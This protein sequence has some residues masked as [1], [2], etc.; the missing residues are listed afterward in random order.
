LDEADTYLRSVAALPAFEGLKI[1]MTVRTGEAPQEIMASAKEIGADV[2]AMTPHGRTDLKRLLFG[3]VAEA[4]L[5]AAEIPVFML[6]A[7]PISRPR[8]EEPNFLPANSTR[9]RRS[10]TAR[11]PSV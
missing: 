1:M 10:Y 5:R 8:C 9:A 11:P 2:I 3:S 7:P 6:R 4:V